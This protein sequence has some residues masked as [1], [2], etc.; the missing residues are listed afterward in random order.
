M[1]FLRYRAETRRT[2][3]QWQCASWGQR[4][5]ECLHPQEAIERLDAA[6]IAPIARALQTTQ[7]QG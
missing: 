7:G 1:R 2:M 4:P 5:L 6:A 3:A